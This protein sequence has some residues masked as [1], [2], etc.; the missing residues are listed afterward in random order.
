MR[1]KNLCRI[2]QLGYMLTARATL[3]TNLTLCSPYVLDAPNTFDTY[4]CVYLT[5]LALVYQRVARLHPNSR[6]AEV[7]LSPHMHC[8]PLKPY[9]LSGSLSRCLSR[10]ITAPTIEVAA[11]TLSCPMDHRRDGHPRTIGG[12]ECTF[13]KQCMPIAPSSHR[14]ITFPLHPRARALGAAPYGHPVPSA[15]EVDSAS[16]SAP[17]P[18]HCNYHL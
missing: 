17:T 1:R 6:T 9:S 8:P 13:S 3:L 2:L 7:Y 16:S 10:P 12:P 15:C 11:P 4:Q 5:R 18:P 14:T